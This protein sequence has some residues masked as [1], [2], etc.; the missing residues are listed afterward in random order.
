MLVSNPDNSRTWDP[1]VSRQ[2][3]GAQT[4]AA[5]AVMLAMAGEGENRPNVALRPPPASSPSPPLLL[6]ELT[7]V[8]TTA[9]T[10]TPHTA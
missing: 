3:R 9:T 5:A 8:V 1:G 7:H 2:I 10:T 6:E 4:A